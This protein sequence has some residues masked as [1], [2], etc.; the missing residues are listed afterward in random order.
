MFCCVR[1][2]CSRVA[3]GTSAARDRLAQRRGK[4]AKYYHRVQ[5]EYYYEILRRFHDALDPETYLEIGARTGES[6]SIGRCATIAVDPNFE[7][8]QNVIGRKPSCHFYQMTSDR[9]FRRY[10]PTSVFGMPID[11]AFLDGLHCA[12]F[13]LRDFYNTERHCRRNSVI[14]LH[15]CLPG[16]LEI[17]ARSPADPI[18]EKA[19]Q[20]GF[21]RGMSGKCCPSCSIIDPT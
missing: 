21:G 10:S 16:E 5:G 9:F 4:M 2:G 15:D 12:E 18:G 3:R 17:T 8:T 7:I 14:V 1:E 19:E 20:R 11:L 6:L 13:L